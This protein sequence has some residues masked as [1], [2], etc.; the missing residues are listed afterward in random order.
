MIHIKGA[1]GT[2][3]GVFKSGLKKY[4][5][6]LFV[7]EAYHEDAAVRKKIVFL[8]TPDC[9]VKSLEILA[10]ARTHADFDIVAVV[11]QPPAPAGRNKK[12]VPSP[13]HVAA[14]KLSIPV[15]CPEKAK[16]PEFLLQLEKLE[17]DLCITAAYGNFLPTSFLKL[18]KRGTVNIHPSLL[19]LY[20]GAAPVQRCLENGD[21]VTGVSVVFTVLKMDAGPIIKQITKNLTGNEKA[22][23]LLPEM[24]VV[25][26]EELINLLPAIFADNISTTPQDEGQ[27]TAAP[28]LASADARTDFSC[29][30]A[31]VIHNKLRGYSEWPGIWSTFQFGN[32]TA[33]AKRIK[34]ITTIVISDAPTLAD[35]TA[36]SPSTHLSR[37]VQPIKH[38]GVDCLRVVC[39]DGSVLGIVELQPE[40]KKVMQCKTFLN[41]LRGEPLFWCQP[42]PLP[43]PTELHQQ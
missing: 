35:A 31:R 15:L 10:N 14:D 1:C 25:G 23:E 4:A 30:N 33:E 42:P 5:L 27:A 40:S 41:G 29:T 21:P 13:V 32:E 28:K 3:L 2:R 6:K 26:T 43:A 7:N 18:P 11:T 37:Q 19:P 8:G 9:A 17:P 24:F 22:T 39:G 12:L 38:N 20:R 36:T 16:D 34:I